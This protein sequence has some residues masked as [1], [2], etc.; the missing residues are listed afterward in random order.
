MDVAR[1]HKD[2][3][4]DIGL[5][6]V[7]QTWARDLHYHVH[8]HCVVPGGGLST[9]R[10]RWIQCSNDYFLPQRVLALRLRTRFKAAL[11]KADPKLFVQIPCKVW[12]MAWVVDVLPVGRGEAALKYLGAYVYR[13]A[14]SSEKIIADDGKNIT[15]VCRDNKGVK[16][17]LTRPAETFIHRVL[18]HVLP[19]RF[20]HVRSYGWLSPAAKARFERIRAMLDWK[21]PPLQILPRPA[22]ECPCCHKPMILVQVLPRP[23]P[24]K[25]G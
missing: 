16:R 21:A 24:E 12:Q 3:G 19:R 10:L 18:Q 4:A 25:S 14:F 17:T 2:L 7:L 11:Q 6:A 20:Q 8:I 23:P 5:L 13:S 22:P 15:F 9:D 1:E